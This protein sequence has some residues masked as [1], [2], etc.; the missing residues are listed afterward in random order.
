MEDNWRLPRSS[1]PNMEDDWQLTG[2]TYYILISH[3][4]KFSTE[5]FSVM[6]KAEMI[7]ISLKYAKLW[8]QL[9]ITVT[10]KM[11]INFITSH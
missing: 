6:S 10:N 9:Y 4:S 2:V 5:E 11:K 3:K 1:K 7:S 8:I